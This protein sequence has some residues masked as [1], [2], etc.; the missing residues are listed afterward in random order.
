MPMK[1]D[2]L[3]RRR[4]RA[5]S[6]SSARAEPPRIEIRLGGPPALQPMFCAVAV[7]VFRRLAPLVV[8]GATR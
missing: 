3:C 8:E 2:R 5:T 7:G 6:I 4:A 1:A